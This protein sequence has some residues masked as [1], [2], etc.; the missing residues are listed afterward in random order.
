MKSARTFIT[1]TVA[2]LLAG[3]LALAQT[4]QERPD[5]PRGGPG[6]GRGPGGPGGPGAMLDNLLP[7]RVIEELKLTTEQKAKYD[8]LQAAFK[9]DAD[10]WRSEHPDSAEKMRKAREAGDRETLRKLAEERRPLM[11]ARRSYVDKFRETLTA[12][13]KETLDKAMEQVR[14]R[15]GRGGPGGPPPATPQGERPQPGAPPA[16]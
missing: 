5:R 4:G 1:L 6:G 10:K 3:T 2:T 9:K 11:D 14:G 8:E 13:Q 16:D 15:R 12:E 7:P